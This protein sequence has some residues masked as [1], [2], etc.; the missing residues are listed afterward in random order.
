MS[1]ETT[2]PTPQLAQLEAA[3]AEIVERMRAAFASQAAASNATLQEAMRL[4]ARLRRGGL[5]ELVA[6]LQGAPPPPAASDT[7]IED[8]SPADAE[9]VARSADEARDAVAASIRS[10]ADRP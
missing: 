8:L 4:R 1:D 3:T 2:G 10:M 6:R 7:P 5:L 9:A